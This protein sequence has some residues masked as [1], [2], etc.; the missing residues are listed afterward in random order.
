[1]S[2]HA[3]R[4]ESTYR[5]LART[6]ELVTTESK[7]EV[8]VYDQRAHHIHHLDA[9]VTSVWSN[10][11]G[12]RTPEAIS[13]ATGIDRVRVRVSLRKLDECQ[14][15]DS[16]L[17][18]ELKEPTG[19]RRKFLRKAGIA[20]LPAIVSV[21]APIAKAAASGGSAGCIVPKSG[22]TGCYSNAHCCPSTHPDFVSYCVEPGGPCDYERA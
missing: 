21:T 8:L 12:T 22:D 1:M 6:E 2:R 15:L 14:L 5:P 11:D 4:F 3:N 7:D 9:E 18:A 20:A 16:T 19:S 10:C 17:P 13:L